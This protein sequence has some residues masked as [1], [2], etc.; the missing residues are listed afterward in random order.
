MAIGHTIPHYLVSN[1]SPSLAREQGNTTIS[2]F[3]VSPD[4][5]ESVIENPTSTD[6][7]SLR[8]KL[9][10]AADRTLLLNYIRL[11]LGP[12]QSTYQKY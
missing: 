4:A 7:E 8:S 9:V 5:C 3:S 11:P 2:L 6:P 1:Y 10:P 12:D